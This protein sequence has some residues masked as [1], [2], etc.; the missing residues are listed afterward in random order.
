MEARLHRWSPQEKK[1]IYTVAHRLD[2]EKMGD[3]VDYKEWD[4]FAEERIDR[5]VVRADEVVEIYL[6]FVDYKQEPIR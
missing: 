4:S 2:P 3:F 5:V 1:Y 6:T